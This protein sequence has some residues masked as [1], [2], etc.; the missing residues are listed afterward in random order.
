MAVDP[1][2]YDIEMEH[3]T[4]RFG[5]FVAVKDMDLKIKKGEFF[6]MLGPS[7]CGKTTTLRMVAG[8]EEPTEGEIYLANTPVAGVPPYKRPVNTVFQSYALFPHLSVW[9]NV[10]FGLKRKHV[11]KKEIEQRVG[12][13]IAMVEMES[14]KDRKP[15]QLSGGQQQRVALARA[16]VNR[17]TVLLL[18][19]PLGALDAKLRKAM[20][21]E[22]KKLQSDVGITFIYVTHDQEEALTMSDRL[23]VMSQG[24]VEQVGTPAEIYEN[25]QSAFVANFIGVSNIYLSDVTRVEGGVAECRTDKGLGVLVSAHGKD[26]KAGDKV[27]VVIRPEKFAI[28]PVEKAAAISD[29]EN[30]FDGVIKAIVYIGSVTQFIVDIEGKHLAQ[31]LFQN[32]YHTEREEWAEDQKVKVACWKDSASLITDVKTGMAEKDLMGEVVKRI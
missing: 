19:E 8:F 6:S 21:L 32:L 5:D 25:P 12:E 4:K 9:E 31:I 3:V 15:V 28:A 30:V 10:A 23:A 20:Q 16:L 29:R 14:M 26:I 18:D 22:L 24:V 27:G 1:N 7:G 17:P 13:A 11:D 2:V